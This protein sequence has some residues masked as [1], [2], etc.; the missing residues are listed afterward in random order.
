VPFLAMD[1][2][3]PAI[4]LHKDGL[5]ARPLETGTEEGHRKSRIEVE[6][7]DS[8]PLVTGLE[9]STAAKIAPRQFSL[10]L[11]RRVRPGVE[12]DAMDLA[13]FGIQENQEGPGPACSY[14]IPLRPDREAWGHLV[15]TV[16][17]GGLEPIADLKLTLWRRRPALLFVWPEGSG[18]ELLVLDGV[19]MAQVVYPLEKER[20]AILAL[21]PRDAI[22]DTEATAVDEAASERTRQIIL[23]VS[24]AV[25]ALVLLGI[26]ARSI[27]PVKP[28][29]GQGSGPGVEAPK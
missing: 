19:Q 3:E 2:P 12:H 4:A 26:L 28:A 21:P 5:A 14:S 8:W 18:L 10:R 17:D 25:A 7:P 15:L 9:I 29:G 16:Q 27:R 11:E 23:T 20:P 6:L 1:L 24:L 22:L 13:S